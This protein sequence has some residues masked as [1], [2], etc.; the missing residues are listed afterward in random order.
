MLDEETVN[1]SP[2]K[3][4]TG[5]EGLDISGADA[6]KD[7]RADPLYGMEGPVKDRRC[8]GKNH[9][10]GRS[11][12]SYPPL[13]SGVPLSCTSCRYFRASEN[14]TSSEAVQIHK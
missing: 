9:T 4:E 12:A 14:R 6:A 8:L 1:K 5:D 7:T 2:S 13:R 10:L 3:E 11:E